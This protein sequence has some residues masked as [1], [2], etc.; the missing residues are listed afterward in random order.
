MTEV[1][2]DELIYDWNLAGEVERPCGKIQFDDETL[3]DGLQSPSARDPGLDDNLRLLQLM[4][5]LGIDTADVGLP[6]AG[7]RAREHIT[8]LVRAT[9]ELDIGANVA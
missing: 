3:R 2:R 4:D 6:G 7:P 8:A 1:R 9:G 5:E